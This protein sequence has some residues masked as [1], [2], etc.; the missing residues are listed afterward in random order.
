M[1]ATARDDRRVNDPLTREPLPASRKVHVDGIMRGVRV[2]M[3]EIALTDG[4]AL[5]VYDTS[6]PYT[7]PDVEIDVSRGLAP[8]RA[9]W[10]EARGDTELYDGRRVRPVDDGRRDEGARVTVEGLE[11][12]PRRALPGRCVTQRHYA[13]QGVVTPEMEFIAI[14][15]NQRLDQYR[16]W[17]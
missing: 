15:E 7:D 4:T 10:I 8:L 11:R 16:A 14:R 3:R 1:P 6:G 9:P 2:P 17:T 5:T 13:L 12:R